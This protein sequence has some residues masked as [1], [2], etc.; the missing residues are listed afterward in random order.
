M[1]IE[2]VLLFFLQEVNNNDCVGCILYNL[3]IIINIYKY[4]NVE[5]IKKFYMNSVNK[6]YKSS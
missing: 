2:G 4:I 1:K 3:L 5:S 6:I